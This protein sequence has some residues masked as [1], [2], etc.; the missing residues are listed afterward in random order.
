VNK[1][2]VDEIEVHPSQQGQELFR[3]WGLL[4]G[5]GVGGAE[6]RPYQDIGGDFLVWHVDEVVRSAAEGEGLNRSEQLMLEFLKSIAGK[7]G[8]FEPVVEVVLTTFNVEGEAKPIPVLE[9][10]YLD[11]DIIETD[12]GTTE[13][14]R[15]VI[16]STPLVSNGLAYRPGYVQSVNGFL[17]AAEMI[18]ETGF[19]LLNCDNVLD[20]KPKWQRLGIRLLVSARIE[21]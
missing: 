14:Q 1:Y 11:L 10:R 2:P 3:L 20:L 4:A 9:L 13:I 6:I 12:F 8:E 18:E 21:I 17:G 19:V 5:R 16:G 7:R 15:K